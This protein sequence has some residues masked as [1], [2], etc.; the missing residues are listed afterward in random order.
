ML[1]G[2]LLLLFAGVLLALLSAIA[3]KA[4]V[5]ISWHELEEYCR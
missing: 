4:L 3:H 2:T 1:D 5:E